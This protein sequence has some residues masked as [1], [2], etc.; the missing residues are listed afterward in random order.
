MAQDESKNSEKNVRAAKESVFI[1]LRCSRSISD[2]GCGTSKQARIQCERFAG[3]AETGR[4]AREFVLAFFRPGANRGVP[5]GRFF[6]RNRLHILRR[7]SPQHCHQSKPR[8]AEQAD[9][10]QQAR[11]R[12]E[13][14]RIQRRESRSA[15]IQF[16]DF[17]LDPPEHG[18]PDF[19]EAFG[20]IEQFRARL[21][22][23]RS[24]LKAPNDFCPEAF[25]GRDAR[26][27]PTVRVA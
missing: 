26:I 2:F 3:F 4:A 8:R 17:F 6:C 16:P 15:L 21:P 25:H 23:G 9:H 18:A 5:S 11:S 13:I 22:G 19:L 7:E 12:K 10:Q 24:S 27:F 20:M 14:C 1:R